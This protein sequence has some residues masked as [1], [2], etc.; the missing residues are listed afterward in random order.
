MGTQKGPKTP[1]LGPGKGSKVCRG[2]KQEKLIQTEK[3]EVQF[4]SFPLTGRLKDLKWNRKDG[5]EWIWKD[6]KWNLLSKT[7]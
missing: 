5:T 1:S 4:V 7:K 3:T 6:L 2:K